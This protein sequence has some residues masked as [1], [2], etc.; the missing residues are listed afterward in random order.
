MKVQILGKKIELA[1]PKKVFELY[2]D[3]D[4]KY[5]CCLVDNKLKDLTYEITA[6]AI[7]DLLDINEEAGSA[8]TARRQ[9][10]VVSASL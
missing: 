8:V 6:D 1:K 4:K 7:I 10:Y 2:E 9:V 5:L 3:K